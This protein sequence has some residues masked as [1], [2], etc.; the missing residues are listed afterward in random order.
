MSPPWAPI[1]PDNTRGDNFGATQD[2]LGKLGYL[3]YDQY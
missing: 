3:L 2:F 1:I